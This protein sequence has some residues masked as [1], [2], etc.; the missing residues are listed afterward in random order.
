MTKRFFGD[1]IY[2]NKENRKKMKILDIECMGRALGRPPKVQTEEQREREI[3]GVGLRNEAEATFGTTKRVYRGD[4]I[5]AKLPDTAQCWT[6]MCYF[7][8]NLAKFMRELCRLL[9]KILHFGDDKYNILVF[10]QKFL[11]S[12]PNMRT[13]S[14]NIV[15]K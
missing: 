9:T 4:N 13:V 6:A 14:L 2:L 11:L 8:K 7:V 10:F 1:K 5:K 12:Q 15:L 3:I